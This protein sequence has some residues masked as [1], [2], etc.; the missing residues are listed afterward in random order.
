VRPP[1]RAAALVAAS[2]A[3]A[4]ALAAA[5]DPP[6]PLAP[7][8]PVAPPPPAPPPPAPPAPDTP[9]RPDVAPPYAPQP[10]AP[11]PYAPPAYT[12]PAPPAAPPS[13]AP[14]PTGRLLGGLYLPS[15]ALI[16][17]AFVQSHLGVAVEVGRRWDYGTISTYTPPGVMPDAGY[18]LQFDQATNV[19]TQYG[20][21]GIA[22]N[23]RVELGVSGSYQSVLSTDVA[24]V[25]VFGAKS[26]WTLRPLVRF[27]LVRTPVTA[28]AL[29]LYGDFGGDNQQSPVTALNEIANEIHTISASSG[30]G[31]NQ[32]NCLGAGDV[33]CALTNPSAVNTATTR[34]LAGGGTTLAVAHAF[35]ST[36][37]IQSAFGLEV[38]YR[39][40]D[41]NGSSTGSVPINF[42]AGVAPSVDFGPNAPLALMLEYR[43]NVLG[44]PS[45]GDGDGNIVQVTNALSFG[46]Y[47]TGRKDL[48]LG[49]IFSTAFGYNQIL[50]SDGSSQ[51]YPPTTTVTGQIAARYFF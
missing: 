18:S 13:S 22:V 4:P 14:A 42:H 28:V 33:T 20:S 45:V 16:D 11:P 47:Y 37:G 35:N 8:E 15:P 24:S 2:V 32:T 12:P 51:L 41:A 36:F 19:S 3:L 6:P 10:Y 26:S 38:G 17:S 40:T 27:Q 29:L 48:S 49:A 31:Q 7:A 30:N 34:T 50:F 1:R 46:V 9:P 21:F 23:D 25:L 44:E 39:A 5:Q 43:L